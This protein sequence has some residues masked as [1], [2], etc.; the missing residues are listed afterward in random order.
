MAKPAST[1]FDS[2]MSLNNMNINLATFLD[3]TF[4][5]LVHTNPYYELLVFDCLTYACLLYMLVSV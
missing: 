3:A 4:Y 2:R 5:V 1:S